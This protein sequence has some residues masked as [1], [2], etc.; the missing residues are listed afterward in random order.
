MKIR[1]IKG[2]FFFFLFILFASCTSSKMLSPTE[3]EALKP[4]EDFL[5]LHTH[6]KKYHVVNYTFKEDKLIG[7]LKPYK[8]SKGPNIHIHITGNYNI[9]L[10]ENHYVPIELKYTEIS[11][12]VYQKP[13]PGKTLVLIATPIILFLVGS[14]IYFVATAM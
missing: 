6:E 5:V 13:A 4:N 14:S 7:D 2:T 9:I 11:K 10:G 1:A 8:R 12:M 3:A